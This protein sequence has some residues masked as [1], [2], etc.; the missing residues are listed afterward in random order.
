MLLGAVLV[1]RPPGA[2]PHG[3]L[4]AAA[5]LCSQAASHASRAAPARKQGGGLRVAGEAGTA[6]SAKH[7]LC[8]RASTGIHLWG[9]SL[10]LLSFEKSNSAGL[11]RHV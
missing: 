1:L 8:T 9:N 2:G 11:Q 7:I 4:Q 3:A 10:F 5:V 6:N